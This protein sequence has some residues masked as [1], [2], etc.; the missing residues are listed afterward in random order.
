MLLLFGFFFFFFFP[1]CFTCCSIGR[2]NW[3]FVFFKERFVWFWFGF[4]G[5]CFFGFVFGLIW[6]FCCFGGFV[7]AV[8]L[9]YWGFKFFY[10]CGVF[11]FFSYFYWLLLTLLVVFWLY[12]S[13]TPQWGW[14]LLCPWH[15]SSLLQ[16]RAPTDGTAFKYLKNILIIPKSQ[17]IY[18]F[19][20]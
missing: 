17:I 1:Y 5:F 3:V 11:N 14:I 18:T 2:K 20:K 7:V 10:F 4:F 19:R 15:W 12:L 8:C 9:F 6:G 16:G 13:R